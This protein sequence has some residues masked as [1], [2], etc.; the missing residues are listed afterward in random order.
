MGQGMSG[1]LESVTWN[2]GMG[3]V[4]VLQIVW[5]REEE[6]SAARHSRV[7]FSLGST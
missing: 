5:L 7:R 4:G 1:P 3:R 6:G 2:C